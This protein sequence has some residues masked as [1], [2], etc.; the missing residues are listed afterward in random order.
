MKR[1][2]SFVLVVIGL[3]LFTGSAAAESLITAARRGD[4]NA[5]KDLLAK[6][7]D[8]NATELSM[9]ALTWAAG[10]GH[11]EVAKL[12]IGRGA[13]VNAIGLGRTALMWAASEGHIETAKLL[14]ERGADVNKGRETGYTAL[15]LAAFYRKTE[16]AKFLIEEGADMK[17]AIEGLE[18]SAVK[19]P[20]SASKYKQGIVL[21]EG[22]K[23]NKK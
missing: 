15:M 1:L 2:I 3:S 21:L 16:T 4:I 18:R 23:P 17:A 22:L 6:G 9:T 8:V 11:T 5:V 20:E 14:I 10:K 13:D 7:A 12:L 19:Y